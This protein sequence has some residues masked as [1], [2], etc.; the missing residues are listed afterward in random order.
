MNVYF[1]TALILIF[2]LLLAWIVGALLRLHGSSLWLLRGGLMLIG[3]VA[4][5][6]FLWFHHRLKRGKNL[7]SAQ[8]AGAAEQLK[9]LLRQAEQKLTMGKQGSLGSLPIVFVLGDLNSAKTSSIIHSGLEPEL[10]AGHVFRDSDI[11]PTATINVWFAR[12]TV[13]IEAG[14]NLAANPQLWAQVL[15]QTRPKRIS[16]A[17]GQGQ[18]APRAALVCMDSEQLG[19]SQASVQNLGNRLKEMAR[20]LGAPFPVYVLFTK[21]DRL[22]HFADFVSNLTSE[23]SAQILGATLPRA[24]AQG[25]FAEEEN[26]RLTRAFDQIIYALA[27]K[28]VDFLSRETVAQKAAG[29]YEFPRELRKSRN[30]LVQLLVD[31]TRPTQLS[32]NPFL[33]GF[34]FSG[35]RAIVINEAVSA[36]AAARTAVAPGSGATRMFNYAEEARAASQNVPQRAVQSRKVPEWTFLPHL[37][38]EA[39]LADRVAFSASNQSTRVDG[40]RRGLLISVALL[41]LSFAVAL[42]VSFIQNRGLE[43]QV[44]QDAVHLN[45]ISAGPAIQNPSLDQL[46]TLDDLRGAVAQLTK[47]QNEGAPWSYRFGLYSGDRIHPEAYRLYFQ[48]FRRLLL[49]STQ[50]RMVSVLNQPPAT[51]TSDDFQQMYFTLKAYLITT[52]NHEHA[53]W[54]S[55]PQVLLDNSAAFKS[56]DPESPDLIRRQ[57]AFYADT[58]LAKNPYGPENEGAAVEQARNYLKQFDALQAIY[59]AMLDDAAKGSKPVN[60]NR[61][62]PQ[63]TAYV[64][65]G[66]EVLPAFT[67]NG[68][69]VIQKSLQNPEKFRG[70]EWVLGAPTT[71]NVSAASLRDALTSKYANDYITQWRAYLKNGRVVGYGG[72][73]DASTKLTRLV[74]ND[75]PLLQLLWLAKENTAVDIPGLKDPFNAVQTIARDST[76]ERLVG[77]GNQEYMGAL[78][79]LQNSLQTVVNTPNGPTD[80]GMLGQLQQAATGASGTVRRIE[81]LFTVDVQGGPDKVDKNVSRLL[82][83]PIDYANDAAKRAGAAGADDVCKM[84]NQVTGKKPFNP[85][86]NQQASWP[87]VQE[88]FRPQGTLWSTVQTKMAT[89]VQHQGPTWASAGSAPQSPNFLLFLNHAQQFTDMLFPG[90]SPT[91]HLTYTLQ[92]P[93]TIGLY[94]TNLVIDGQSLTDGHSQ[95]FTWQGGNSSITLSVTAAGQNLANAP[96][97][98]PWALFEF[99]DDAEWSGNNPAA[100][101][102]SLQTT[103]ELGHHQASGSTKTT[104]HYQLST[105]GTNIFRKEFL[106]SL[107]C[108]A[109]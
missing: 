11:V 18:Q 1:V 54:N 55:F 43:N 66:Y 35:V 37:F 48:N 39:V 49:A 3:I 53:D 38:T 6:L 44:T 73:K 86:S 97:Q 93:P 52:S 45:A 81:L 77:S 61:Q 42:L 47:Y 28:R 89:A 107:H 59:Q 12:K 104:V 29:I 2:Y 71:V 62:F 10:I 36:P 20:S 30:Q 25:V 75:S 50:S 21:L 87:E 16:A 94:K 106:S 22:P 4:A 79:G 9:L 7:T 83:E 76:L 78:S 27:E 15:R 90:G 69:A 65:D 17:M 96:Y 24:T 70:E 56:A 92:S 67:K 108:S 19:S 60:F 88:L 105:Q 68:Y 102:Y 91:V 64:V 13:F 101:S 58:L 51:R 98:G 40:L 32:T 103:T 23:E 80:P 8:F 57:F 95:Q 100:L 33:R 26:K 63:A 41:L 84:V 109:R 46:R 14:G 34:Y 72:L 31:L 85:R 5:G 99:F 82:E 74:A